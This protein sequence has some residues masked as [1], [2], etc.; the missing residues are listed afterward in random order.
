MTNIKPLYDKVLIKRVET[1]AKTAGGIILP[2]TA[3][4]DKPKEAVVVA[5]GEGVRNPDGK[6]I[7]LIVKKGDK[8]LFSGWSNNEVDQTHGEDL[9]IIKE[10]DIDAIIA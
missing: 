9:L 8:V 10:S 2:D 7:P 5:V 6:I 3:K 4:Q 1:L